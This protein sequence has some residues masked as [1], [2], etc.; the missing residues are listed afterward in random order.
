MGYLRFYLAFSLAALSVISGQAD[1]S[2]GVN[3]LS[4]PFTRWGSISSVSL[5][6]DR[7]YLG[8]RSFLKAMAWLIQ[9]RCCCLNDISLLEIY[10]GNRYLRMQ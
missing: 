1:D 4:R 3:R 10:I 7:L 9:I 6:E 5:D 2:L 8:I